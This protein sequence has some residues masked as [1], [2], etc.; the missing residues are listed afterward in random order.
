[1]HHFSLTQCIHASMHP[2]NNDSMHAW[3]T[4]FLT[5]LLTYVFVKLSFKHPIACMFIN[6]CTLCFSVSIDLFLH[7]SIYIYI[8]FLC[9]S[10][11]SCARFISV[12]APQ[13]LPVGALLMQN[14]MLHECVRADM[15]IYR[16]GHGIVD[17]CTTYTNVHRC[18]PE[19]VFFLFSVGA[20]KAIWCCTK[21]FSPHS[22]ALQ[23]GIHII[24][25]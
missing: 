6:L 19:Y 1:M 2:W 4:Y 10:Q 22:D 23:H 15:F 21:C 25:C 13:L 17:L 12:G 24:P 11:R 3:I 8:Y 18:M 9:A 7:V 16:Y 20:A 5:A 14:S